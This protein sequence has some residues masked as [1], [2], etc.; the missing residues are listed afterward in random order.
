M[1]SLNGSLIK[2]QRADNSLAIINNLRED[3]GLFLKNKF[4]FKRKIRNIF[5]ICLYIPK[6][7]RNCKSY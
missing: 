5:L 3:S 4:L 6:D 1:I 7:I 2:P